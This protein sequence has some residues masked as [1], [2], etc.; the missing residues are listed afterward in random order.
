MTEKR[1][2][3]ESVENG[4][5]NGVEN[6]VKNGVKN[7]VKEGVKNGVE[8]RGQADGHLEGL[9]DNVLR[10]LH[11]ELAAVQREVEAYP[12]D[13]SLWRVAPGISNSG[14]TLALHLA[15]NVRHFVGA[16][17][18][19]SG[20]KR[21]RDA[22]FSARGLPR[23]HVSRELGDAMSQAVRALRGLDPAKLDAEFPIAVGPGLT[24]RTDVML[25]HLSVHAG[26]HLGQIDYHRRMIAGDATTVGTLPMPALL[27]S[28]PEAPDQ[29]DM[30]ADA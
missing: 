29:P 2:D 25:L 28:L 26:Y 12:D 22:E 7:S 14:G 23:E 8:K 18:G 6:N 30:P 4:V 1:R 16:V 9:R 15:G 24:L 3:A 17:L 13:E 19:G 20:Y 27:E 11:R 10:M 5:E 21:D